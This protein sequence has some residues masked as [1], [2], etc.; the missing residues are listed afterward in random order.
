M[1]QDLPTKDNEHMVMRNT[2]S[3]NPYLS[4]NI[5]KIFICEKNEY[6]RQELLN[7]AAMK[8]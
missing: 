7:K 2:F 5:I 4:L 8:S 3:L 6:K 1:F